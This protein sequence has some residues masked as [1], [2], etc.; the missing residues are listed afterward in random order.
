MRAS[1][2]FTA[3]LLACVASAGMSVPAKAQDPFIGQL[4][5]FGSNFCPRGYASASGQILAIS[6]NTALFSL[7]GTTYG[8]NGTT[9]FALPDLR[10]RRAVGQ[11]QGPGLPFYSL[12]QI[13]GTETHTLTVPELGAHSH[14][15]TVRAFPTYGDAPR[16]VRNYIA[17]SADGSN[18]YTSSTTPPSTLMG[19]D[20]LRV[21]NTGGSQPHENRPPYLAMN[22]CVA[23][24]GI[25][26]SR[27]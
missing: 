13:A 8:G 6:Q 19:A 15:G 5:L 1:S 22:W 14:A 23:L 27:N 11:G 3:A 24:E 17:R 25:F 18:N 7:F 21:A 9:T 4:S 10:G 12:G 20:A 2:A 26:P 16:P